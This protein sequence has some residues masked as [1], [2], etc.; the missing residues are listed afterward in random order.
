[1]VRTVLARVVVVVIAILAGAQSPLAAKV[2]MIGLADL[3]DQAE[4]I[5]VVRVER[6]GLGIPVL[7][8]PR[9]T[10]T[11]LESWKGQMTGHVS[12]VAAPTW[13]CDI[14]DAEKNEEA[15]LFVRDGKL[16]HA[17]REDARLHSRGQETGY[18]LE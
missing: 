18:V 2:M 16:L 3:A 7:R 8:Q 6:I 15:I 9:A 1:M 14:S 12:F 4:F 13:I 17:G 11:I 10:A 5:G